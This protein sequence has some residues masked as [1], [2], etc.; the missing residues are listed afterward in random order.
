MFHFLYKRFSLK[1]NHFKIMDLYSYLR[2]WV[3]FPIT[4]A[5]I[6]MPLFSL[7]AQV[8]ENQNPYLLISKQGNMVYAK[9]AGADE[10]RFSNPDAKK[11]IEW[12]LANSS[13]TLLQPGTYTVREWVEIPRSGVSLIIKKNATLRM[14][15]HAASSY[16]SERH[17]KYYPLIYND[18]KDS[19]NVINFGTLFAGGSPGN[20]CILFDGRSATRK[21][22]ITGGMIFSSGTLT[23]CGDAIWTVDSRNVKIPLIATKDYGNAPLASEGCEELDIGMVAGLAGEKG[24]ENETIDLN[25]F[26]ER[27]TIGTVIGTSPA[28][29]ILDI[30]NSPDCTIGEVIGYG[31]PDEMTLVSRPQY[32]PNGR[33]LSIK[34]FIDHSEGT[35]V[36]KT[37]VNDKTVK[38]WERKVDVPEL[39]NGKIAFDVNFQL[40]AE[41]EDGSREVVYD[42]NIHFDLE[43]KK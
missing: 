5:G 9:P 35:V 10:A 21:C 4:L 34:P 22:G 17:G 29:Q 7:H 23:G 32:G 31:N 19:V 40:I 6:C 27:L 28:E 39:S 42:K 13:V 24:R 25:S 8:A 14:H 33:R 36:K 41:F 12:A 1:I 20:V 16:V 37:R 18:R 30:N 15:R 43:H 3:L 11:V 26:N 38:T 2:W